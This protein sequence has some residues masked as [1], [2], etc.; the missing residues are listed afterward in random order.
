MR[1]ITCTS[2]FFS[3]VSVATPAIAQP[4]WELDVPGTQQNFLLR[5]D[6]EARNTSDTPPPCA[7]PNS[8]QPSTREEPGIVQNF[9][10][11][12]EMFDWGNGF[13]LVA[14]AAGA[15]SVS[16][17]SSAAAGIRGLGSDTIVIYQRISTL[18]D[19]SF[20]HCGH[21]AMGTVEANVFFGL[22]IV[23]GNAAAY[24]VSWNS[25]FFAN[26][27]TTWETQPPGDPEDFVG[28]VGGLAAISAPINP[29]DL[30]SGIFNSAVPP[31]STGGTVLDNGVLAVVS[32]NPL[33]NEPPFVII[34]GI[35]VIGDQMIWPNDSDLC[36]GELV[37]RVTLTITGPTPVG[38]CCIN[39][40]PQCIVTVE[41]ACTTT[42]AGTYIGHNTAC[43]APPGNFANPT[44]C[45]RANFNQI[46]GVT[47]Q[48]VFDFLNAW[49]AGDAGA[50][51]NGGGLSIQ[52]IFDFL[53]AWF[54]GC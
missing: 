2:A 11:G 49:F 26:A 43:D 7:G 8:V 48:D 36:G 42:F 27:Q 41:A 40:T 25:E 35:S 21:A 22:R 17:S 45:C 16:A 5:S 29:V 13:D 34:G 3:L 10:V 4:V 30:G 46:G 23:G 53:N 14:I 32:P 31:V 28:T 51:F 20:A 1:R 50:D 24:N 19:A 47:L 9:A 12:P 44:S 38:A 37:N 33:L 52:D 6:L 18:H 39:N 15:G 54:T